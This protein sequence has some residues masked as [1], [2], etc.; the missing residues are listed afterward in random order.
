MS[1]V[2]TPSP[3]RRRMLTCARC[4]AGSASET[5]YSVGCGLGAGRR[6]AS[7]RRRSES[8]G[9]KHARETDAY[10]CMREV[11]CEDGSR[12]GLDLVQRSEVLPA[13]FHRYHRSRHWRELLQR[14]QAAA[15]DA[16]VSTI[17]SASAEQVVAGFPLAFK[18]ATTAA[19]SSRSGSGM[20]S[21]LKTSARTIWSAI[22]RLCSQLTL[23]DFAPKSIRAWLQD[24]P[25]PP[26]SI[27]GAHRLQR[28]RNRRRMMGKV[29]DDGD[30][31]NLGF[32]FQ[33][34]LN[35]AKRPQGFGDGIR[36]RYRN[37]P[38]WQRR[39]L[40]SRRCTLRP[41]KTRS[42][43]RPC[44]RAARASELQPAYV[45][46]PGDSPIG[47]FG[48]AVTL[49][50]AEGAAHALVNI[51]VTIPC[52]QHP[53]ARN[54]VDQA[55]ECSLHFVEILVNV[56]VVELNR[57]KNQQRQ[58]NSAGTSAPYRRRQCRIR[59]PPE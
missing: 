4:L 20:A 33:P 43:P 39:R 17:A 15:R 57:S 23:K 59:R 3:S 6:S 28:L 9:R 8:A 2:R 52:D 5:K 37:W 30:A 32:H 22:A 24:R 41:E 49:D 21:D 56:G 31:V 11:L 50:P 29:V 13:A 27:A 42:Q 1:S 47:T 7:H 46:D 53:A 14:P 45:L 19:G 12:G 55:L 10:R 48:K 54:Q 35:A 16:M 34:S 18:S 38:P 58:E 51:G 25:K 26:P 36:C 40:R 44:H